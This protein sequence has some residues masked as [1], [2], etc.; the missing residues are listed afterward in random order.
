MLVRIDPKTYA[1]NWETE[2]TLFENKEIYKRLNQ[3]T[4]NG[5]VLE[6][7]SGVGLATLALASSHS[8]LA[9]DNN[10][11]LVSK[12][13]ARLAAA[14]STAEIVIADIFEPSAECVTAIRD[15]SP[16]VITGW[17]LGSHADDQERYVGAD[18]P[19]EHWAKKYRENI[20]DA[21]LTTNICPPSVEWVHLAGRTG[22]IAGASADFVS[23]ETKDDYDK[24]VFLPNGFEVIDVQVLDWDTSDSSFQ[25]GAAPNP[26][27]LPGKSIPKILSILAKRKG[28]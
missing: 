3:I 7:G 9:I 27:I 23:Q 5:N 24:Y 10:V 6:I 1:D 12:A 21:M 16:K 28:L 2:S 17:F 25:Y 20:E 4:P 18:V 19:L 8:V 11:H 22:M 15:F 14:K 26:N 13:R